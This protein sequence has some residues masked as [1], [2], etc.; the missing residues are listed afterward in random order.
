MG[1]YTIASSDE[2]H[3]NRI[4]AY[5]EPVGSEMA[6]MMVTGLTTNCCIKILRTDDY[7]KIND[8][9]YFFEA[10]HT[11]MN[12]KSFVGLLGVITRGSGIVFELDYCNRL[13]VIVDEFFKSKIYDASYNVRL[14]MGLH[15]FDTI[16]ID[17]TMTIQT[18]GFMLSTPVLYLLSNVGSKAYMLLYKSPTFRA[19]LK[20][21]NFFMIRFLS[22]NE[23]SDLEG[24][25][26]LHHSNFS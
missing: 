13:K 25:L 3:Y 22:P 18:V 24:S 19:E 9:K 7:I 12:Y 17:K 4:N 1:E 26:R 10:D 11:S 21:Y 14:L 15:P 20:L 6:S 5:F 23:L 2:A 16:Y 8:T